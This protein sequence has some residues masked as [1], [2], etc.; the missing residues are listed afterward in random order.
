MKY[1]RIA[2]IVKAIVI[3]A[4]FYCFSVI[5]GT[6]WNLLYHIFQGKP[7]SEVCVQHKSV[8]YYN[9]PETAIADIRKRLLD[10]RGGSVD[11][12]KNEDTGIATLCLNHPER[13]NAI[14]GNN[15]IITAPP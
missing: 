13:R 1:T 7:L 6:M 3:V 8:N 10:S 5:E 14:S 9:G 12:I 11:V 4:Y 15:N 2:H